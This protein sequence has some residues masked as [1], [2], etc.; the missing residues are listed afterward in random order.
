[1]P[2]SRTWCRSSQD[3]ETALSSCSHN[4]FSVLS[5]FSVMVVAA[6]VL[7]LWIMFLLRF[8]L[9]IS[10][11]ASCQPSPLPLMVISAARS[12]CPLL[13]NNSDATDQSP[14]CSCSV[15]RYLAH[16]TE[17]L[18]SILVDPIRRRNKQLKHKLVYALAQVFPSVFA[19]HSLDA[20]FL[21]RGRNPY[22]LPIVTTLVGE[23]DQ[24]IFPCC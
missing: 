13:R 7:M 1:M 18:L 24:M 15:V 6:V 12:G 4:V 8:H 23:K 21:F 3:G 10:A 9:A 20:Y 14:T 11:R 19:L 22:L 17:P 16:L 2:S 5:L